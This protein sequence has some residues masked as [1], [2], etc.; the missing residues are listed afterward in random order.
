MINSPER[1]AL[2]NWKL[3]EKRV[4][5]RMTLSSVFIRTSLLPL[6]SERY[7]SVQIVATELNCVRQSYFVFMPI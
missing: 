4:S 5:V 1:Y 7:S 6:F 2:L 3:N